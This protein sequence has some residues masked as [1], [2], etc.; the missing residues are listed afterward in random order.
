MSENDP[1]IQLDRSL[2]KKIKTM[3]RLKME[4][5]LQSVFNYGFKEALQL[6]NNVMDLNIFRR[7]ISKIKGIGENRL[8]EVM[9]VIESNI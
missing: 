5:I 9:K 2:Y 8:N 6:K 3:D 7:E 4:E 1:V